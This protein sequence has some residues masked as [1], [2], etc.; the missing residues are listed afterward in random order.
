MLDNVDPRSL[1]PAVGS[2]IALAQAALIAQDNPGRAIGLLDMARVL[3][4]GTLVEDAALR[5]EI[6]LA[7]E[8]ANYEKF[9][10]MAEQ[11]LRRF[12]R[13]VYAESFRRG[14][15]A[16]VVRMGVAGKTNQLT[17]LAGLV[18]GLSAHEQLRLYLRIAQT[19]VVGGKIDAA[20]WASEKVAQLAPK[21][22]VE[23][24][25]ALL[26]DGAAAVLT[27]DYEHGLAE[28]KSLNA[29]RLPHADAGLKEAALGVAQGIRR[30]PQT[31][32]Q[33]DQNTGKPAAAQSDEPP[34]PQAA[35]A[36]AVPAGLAATMNATDGAISQAQ[37]MLAES[38]M[39]LEA[40][41]Q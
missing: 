34:G 6:F 13:S 37:K 15:S 19:A 27:K 17:Q 2:Y 3:A 31:Q 12:R 36:G 25:R 22:S 39:A 5:R 7:E 33:K 28:L 21:N 32:E 20:R 26:Y 35:G 30:W 9:V 10:D 38:D 8:T 16:A 1:E 23:A 41:A 11:Y 4:P 40:Q 14:F 24:H 29:K 18:N